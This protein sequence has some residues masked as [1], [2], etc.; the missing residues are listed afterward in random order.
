MKQVVKLTLLE[1]S[2]DRNPRLSVGVMLLGRYDN[3][4]SAIHLD[5]VHE[6]QHWD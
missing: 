2:S 6:A 5:W 4:R 1:T 3:L